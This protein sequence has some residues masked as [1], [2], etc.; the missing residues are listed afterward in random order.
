MSF[1]YPWLLLALPLLFA[2]RFL[3]RPDQPGVSIPSL[4]LWKHAGIGRA[5]Y[6]WIPQTLRV[7]A[8][9]MLVIAMARPQAGSTQTKQVSEGIAIELL[10]DVSSSMSM[11]MQLPDRDQTTRMEVAK[12]LVEKFIAGDGE[13]LKGRDGDLLGLITFARYADT[14]SPL[15]FGHDALLQLVRSL[16]IQERPNED[17]TA[18]G[19]ALAVAAARLEQL[20]DP[21]VRAR[22]S[23]EGEVASRVII[24]LT[25]GENNSGQHLPVEAAGLAREWGCRIYC[26]SLGEHPSGAGPTAMPELSEAERVLEHISVETGGVFRTAYDYDSLLSVYAEVDELEQSRIVSRSYTRIT[27]WFGLPLAIALCLLL[28]ALVLDATWLRTV[29]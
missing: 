10:V 22:R 18:Y 9:A 28:P 11:N 2:W 15:T 4:D 13:N 3:Q 1:A 27:E 19:D 24:L 6:L 8:F 5:R 20:D 25:D 14:R 21:E 26:I 7:A 29:P 12:E 16:D 23:L 17:G